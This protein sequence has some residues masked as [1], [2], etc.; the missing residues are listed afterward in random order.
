MTRYLKTDILFPLSLILLTILAFIFD[1]PS[2]VI[3]GFGII[4]TSPSVLVT[5]Y[6]RI[7]GLGASLFNVSTI[8]LMT[9]VLIKLLKLNMT[10]PIF[11]G[12]L[13]IAG[14]AFFGKNILNVLPIYVGIFLNA[15]FQKVEFKSLIIVLLFA[16]GIAPIVSYLIFGTGWAFYLSIPAGILIGLLSG[17]LL[18]IMSVHM[19]RFHKGYNLYNIGFTMGI[20][21]LLYSAILRGVFKLD[22]FTHDS[23]TSE[24]YHL[25][26]LIMTTI[27]SLLFIVLGFIKKPTALKDYPVILKSSGKL[28]SD[29]M[30]DGGPE[31]A[32]INVGIMGLIS[33]LFTLVLNL[34]LNG[35]LISG[36]LTVMGFAAFGKHPKNSIPV[37]L[38]ATIWLLITRATGYPVSTGL[39]I[40]VLFVTAVA[41]I[42][43]RHGFFFGLIA[44][45]VHV[46]L[47]PITYP[48]Q[49]GF[50]LY[51]NGFAA[52]FVAA[53]LIPIFDF[54]R[55]DKVTEE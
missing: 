14:F 54:I 39:A 55:K 50:D 8:L 36:V 48:F 35:P 42:A 12:L 52:G 53:I 43:G 22:L 4:L 17:F 49:G 34:P 20:L 25:E 9:Y 41:P 28:V 40:G 29:F 26:L 16:T 47:T 51:N 30:R 15:K 33:L 37:M 46:L 31:I 7:G 32:M 21:S 44:G 1:T 18:P 11:A 45:F 24:A 6:L 5:D 2:N 19:L 38:G 23:S 13:T 10:G 3:H 27:L